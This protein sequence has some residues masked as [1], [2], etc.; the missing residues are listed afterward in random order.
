[1]MPFQKSRTIKIGLIL[2]LQAD[3]HSGNHTI[4]FGHQS[5]R[6]FLVGRHWALLLQRIVRHGDRGGR[7]SMLMLGGRLLGYNKS[8]DF[9]IDLINT[10]EAQEHSASP[11]SWSDRERESLVSWLRRH[12]KTSSKNSENL[13]NQT[14]EP[15][16]FCAMIGARNYEKPRWQS[17]A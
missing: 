12:S 8:F 10:T 3:L 2:A 7:L 9:L 1:M 16:P 6:E 14:A 17:A 5:F 4:L 15:L 13:P 11:L